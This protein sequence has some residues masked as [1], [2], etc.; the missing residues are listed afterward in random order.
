MTDG[1][2]VITNKPSFAG[3]DIQSY[4]VIWHTGAPFVFMSWVPVLQTLDFVFIRFAESHEETRVM[5]LIFFPLDMECPVH[6]KCVIALLLNQKRLLWKYSNE[7]SNR[8][9]NAVR[10][11]GMKPKIALFRRGVV[12]YI[13]GWGK[14]VNHRNLF[15]G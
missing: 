6:V 10:M 1:H 3:V 11:I 2:V 4:R 8:L 5:R 15:F 14:Y 13:K 9:P 7:F 12:T